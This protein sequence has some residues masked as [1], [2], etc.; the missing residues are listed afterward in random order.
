MITHRYKRHNCHNT[1]LN[2]K[3]VLSSQQ[4]S[5]GRRWGNLGD[6]QNSNS[7]SCLVWMHRY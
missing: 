5:G 3:L 4:V 7:P 1:T 6:V 2:F